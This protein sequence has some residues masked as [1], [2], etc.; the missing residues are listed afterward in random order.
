MHSDI[1]VKPLQTPRR[2]LR[3]HSLLQNDGSD[4]AVIA[5]VTIRRD[6]GK[7]NCQNSFYWSRIPLVTFDKIK[8]SYSSC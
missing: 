4:L 3:D 7:C 1:G 8:T 2:L 6:V 5:K